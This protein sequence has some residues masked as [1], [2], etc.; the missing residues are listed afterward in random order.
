ML[1]GLCDTNE[2]SPITQSIIHTPNFLFGL[3][4]SYVFIQYKQGSGSWTTLS[5][6]GTNNGYTIN[7]AYRKVM[8]KTKSNTGIRLGNRSYDA[9]NMN[10]AVGDGIRFIIDAGSIASTISTLYAQI[11]SLF[12][13]FST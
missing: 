13:Y 6:S 4:G 3:D 1:S 2:L 5:T 11:S 9:S 10:M 12:V 7:N 8:L